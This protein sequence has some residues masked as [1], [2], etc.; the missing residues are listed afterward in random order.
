MFSTQ[1]PNS[2]RNE[3]TVNHAYLTF[4]ITTDMFRLD[5]NVVKAFESALTLLKATN[6]GR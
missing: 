1:K 6:Y 3:I 2:N 4:H 5:T